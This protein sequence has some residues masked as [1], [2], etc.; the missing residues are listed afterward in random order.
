V[1]AAI[2]RIPYPSIL[3]TLL[4]NQQDARLAFVF[5]GAFMGEAS[6]TLDNVELLGFLSAPVASH[7]IPTQP[8]C[9]DLRVP[10]NGRL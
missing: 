10:S 9:P 1:E 6:V 7:P 5:E 3:G 2:I 8:P 4:D